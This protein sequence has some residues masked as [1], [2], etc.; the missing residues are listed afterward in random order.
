MRSHFFQ[1]RKFIFAE[2]KTLNVIYYEGSCCFN[3][4][5]LLVRIIVFCW[6][7][8][9]PDDACCAATKAHNVL[10][11]VLIGKE[12][13]RFK[14]QDSRFKRIYCLIHKIRYHHHSTFGVT[15]LSIS[16]DTL[17]HHHLPL[18]LFVHVIGLLYTDHSPFHCQA[19][20]RVCRMHI[21]YK[22]STGL[23]GLWKENIFIQW[24]IKFFSYWILGTSFRFLQS[25]LL[26]LSIFQ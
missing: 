23:P 5:C 9:V 16:H 21:P 18:T 8:V 19:N 17:E 22:L 6:L 7:I 20:H 15:P 4:G 14:I 3:N 12:D 11:S 2:I 24:H 25:S 1:W 10:S 26:C 13:S